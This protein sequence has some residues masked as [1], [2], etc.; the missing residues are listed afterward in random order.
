MRGTVISSLTTAG[1][2]PPERVL[3]LHGQTYMGG[4]ERC[5]FSHHFGSGRNGDSEQS[6]Q[7]DGKEGKMIQLHVSFFPSPLPPFPPP[8]KKIFKVQFDRAKV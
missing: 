1:D 3:G 2:A 7:C 6:K 5:A 4:E 8:Q